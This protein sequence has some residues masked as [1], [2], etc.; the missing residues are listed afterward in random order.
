MDDMASIEAGYF[1]L[2]N[3]ARRI[4]QWLAAAEAT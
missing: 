1:V 2:A 3:A 4:P